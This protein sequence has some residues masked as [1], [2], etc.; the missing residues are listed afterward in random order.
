MRVLFSDYLI[1]WAIWKH[2]QLL[3]IN[4]IAT[5]NTV[6]ILVLSIS[7]A[8]IYV[9]TCATIN[10]SFSERKNEVILT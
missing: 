1:F 4:E 3:F 9:V 8:N 5:S 2:V 10:I 6:I 7:S